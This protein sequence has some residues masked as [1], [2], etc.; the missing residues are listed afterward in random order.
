MIWF[1]MVKE[2]RRSPG[3][4][5]FFC[6][7]ED[8]KWWKSLDEDTRFNSTWEEFEKI[9]SRRWIKD[10]KIE[11]M[12]KIWNELK[13]AKEELKRKCDEILKIQ[14]LNEALNKEVHKLKQ[15]KG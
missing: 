11:A 15:E 7:G 13:E 10:T 1:M 3:A 6:K 14:H 12:N 8:Y 4:I 9:F 5:G 2:C